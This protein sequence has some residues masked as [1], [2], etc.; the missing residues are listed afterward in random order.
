[1]TDVVGTWALLRASS[2]AADGSAMPPPYGG[3][4]IGRLTLTADGRMA[5]VTCDGRPDVPPGDAHR[6][7]SA[8]S[9]YY[10]TD[11]KTLVTRVHAASEKSRIGGDQIRDV[12]FEGKYM[13][14]QPPLRPYP[15]GR[16]AERRELWWV[17]LAPPSGAKSDITGT[18]ALVRGIRTGPNGE[19]RPAPYGGETGIGRVCLLPSGQL[20]AVLCDMRKDVPTGVEREFSSYCG[21]YTFDGRQLVTTVFANSDPARL[22]GAQI[23]NVTFEG[24]YMVLRHAPATGPAPGDRREMYWERLSDV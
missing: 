19:A 10:T 23:R 14:L 3:R 18:W 12:R 4:P 7:F 16:P 22:G 24:K 1:M 21:N 15:G 13:V 20:M 6:D 8:Y 2:K 11:G 9:G 5:A 17:R